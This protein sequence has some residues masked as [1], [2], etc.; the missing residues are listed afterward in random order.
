MTYDPGERRDTPL[1]RQIKA[2]IQA[3]GPL[4][5]SEFMSQCLWDE[6]HGYY[7]TRKVIGGSGDFITAAEISQ[8]FGEL[9]GLWS[10]V[11]WQQTLGSP[12]TVTLVEFGPGRG[13]MMRDALRAA[14]IVPGYLQALSVHLVEMSE[15]LKAAQR[16]ALASAAVPITWGHNIADFATPA[17][18]IGNEFLD[19][20]PVEQWV[21]TERGWRPRAVGLDRHQQLTFTVVDDTSAREDLDRRF[22]SAPVGAIVELQNV[23]RFAA[24]LRHAAG[25]GPVVAL[26]IDYGHVGDVSGDT[27]Q[28]VRG[29]RHEHPLTSPGEADLSVQ[30]SFFDLASAFDRAG[31]EIDGPVTQAEFLGGLGIV[32]RG[33]R[34][35]G[36]NPA[37]SGEIE[38]GVARLITPNGMGTRFKVIGVRSKGLPKLPGF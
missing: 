34:L 12:A 36:A 30:V 1:A 31:L 35:M 32:E 27:L 5:V 29:H 2:S 10:G 4:P 13:T 11:V 26:L 20:W 24:A 23:E 28:A 22:G 17:I 15:T 9:M 37:R 19:A 8:I 38:A 7:A 25:S 6:A 16:E 3:R 14:R 33:A 18:A 21:K